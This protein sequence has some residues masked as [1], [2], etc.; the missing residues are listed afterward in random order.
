MKLRTMLVLAVSVVIGAGLSIT[1]VFATLRGYYGIQSTLS[2]KCLEPT[3]T[4]VGSQIRQWD[5]GSFTYP[6]KKWYI[7]EIRQ[8]PNG[9]GTNTIQHV[10]TGLCLSSSGSGDAV[11]VTLQYCNSSSAAQQWITVPVLWGTWHYR[12]QN[13]ANG[14]CIDMAGNSSNGFIVYQYT[15][16]DD[17][18]YKGNQLWDFPYWY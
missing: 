14:K 8:D 9:V 12:L 7:N 4:A 6:T 16:I 15:C 11:P 5:C 17:N 1:P 18:L 3:G 2:G 10:Q 13:V